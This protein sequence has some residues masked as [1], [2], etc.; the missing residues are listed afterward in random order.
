ML[1]LLLEGRRVRKKIFRKERRSKVIA[2]VL[3]LALV[4][5]ACAFT[6]CVMLQE[7]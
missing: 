4:V 2:V 3:Q 6:G 5:K 7:L 1:L